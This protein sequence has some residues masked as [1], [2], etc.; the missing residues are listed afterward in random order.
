MLCKGR[1]R[2][3]LAFVVGVD[4][5]GFISL[6]ALVSEFEL[7]IRQTV[8]RGLNF[9]VLILGGRL[10]YLYKLHI[11]SWLI[12]ITCD[13][14]LIWGNY[15]IGVSG[16]TGDG[17]WICLLIHCK[18]LRRCQFLNGV[19]SYWETIRTSSIFVHCAGIQ[20][21]L[22]KSRS[23]NYLSIF[24]CLELPAADWLS[25]SGSGSVI[26]YLIDGTG[27]R[28][29]LLILRTLVL[30]L[31]LNEHWVQL[32]GILVG[33]LYGLPGRCHDLEWLLGPVNAL[34]ILGGKVL[35]RL[36]FESI[37]S[38]LLHLQLIG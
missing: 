24:I 19:V 5:M 17:N 15:R 37:V 9:S 32:S 21:F 34:L 10:T 38:T 16:S 1:G 29:L 11:A 4:D 26:A 23:C 14:L 12:L 33:L 30:L 35:S 31:Y 20:I 6:R 8:R 22:H 18:A 27:Q 2:V 13:N 36:G 7:H 25:G 28:I 3:P